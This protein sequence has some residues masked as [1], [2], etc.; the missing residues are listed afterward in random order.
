[1]AEFVQ[2]RSVVHFVSGPIATWYAAAERLCVGA[3]DAALVKLR[4]ALSRLLDEWLAH[5]GR[6]A[7]G[8]SIANRAARLLKYDPR[9]QDLGADI[10]ALRKLGNLGAHPDQ[11]PD[12]PTV[13]EAK[14]GLRTL[15][16]LLSAM[17][18]RILGVAEQD[19]LAFVNPPDTDWPEL[20][21]RA[22]FD[23][24]IDAMLTVA[25]RHRKAG[26]AQFAREEEAARASR[27]YFIDTE[28]S[29]RSRSAAYAWYRRARELGKHPEA[30]YWE[31]R[32]LARGLGVAQDLKR[33]RDLLELAADFEQADALA[34]LAH[35]HLDPR[36]GLVLTD[37]KNVDIGV[38]FA[39]RAA[40]LDHP[41]AL[42]LL[43]VAFANGMGVPADP[44][45]ALEYAQRASDAGYEIAHVNLAAFLVANPGL[46]RFAGE[47][48]TLLAQGRAADIPEAWWYTY[49]MERGEPDHPLSSAAL[50]ALE[51]A[52]KR[53]IYD[54]QCDLG[55]RRLRGDG[56]EADLLWGGSWIVAA[57]DKHHSPEQ[58]APL[59]ELLAEIRD[60]ASHEYVRMCKRGDGSQSNTQTMQIL[61]FRA[62][63]LIWKPEQR[64]QDSVLEIFNLLGGIFQPNGP[65]GPP[66]DGDVDLLRKLLPCMVPDLSPPVRSAPRA[67]RGR[68]ARTPSRNG[69]C[70]CGSGR[71]YKACCSRK[72]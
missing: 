11:R 4:S 33:A 18:T 72:P 19:I 46:E 32:S 16:R 71:K 8:E 15:H 17:A 65:F 67:E 48:N 58:R 31:G 44:T 66:K 35:S 22:V 55:I 30:T 21:H 13:E 51:S 42:N 62:A 10:E 1:V 26:D 47:A 63:G 14:R 28:S 5:I 12:P 9:H 45:K 7:P 57:F 53:N 3:P 39:L 29:D 70:G 56:V 43:V 20:A 41:A 61:A 54:A 52:A 6:P 60:R 68:Q 64:S 69:L 37:E 59:R 34:D 2:A 38:D 23:H 36:D 50:E 49:L 40:A 27:Q 25:H 24:D